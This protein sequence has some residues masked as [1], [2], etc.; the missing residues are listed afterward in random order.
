MSN[1]IQQNSET[2]LKIKY[3]SEY[4]HG[5]ARV[6]PRHRQGKLGHLRTTTTIAVGAPPITSGL[7]AVE[8][9]AA[10]F[11]WLRHYLHS[12]VPTQYILTRALVFL[13]GTL[14]IPW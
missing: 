11:R 4:S 10:A 5:S 14:L 2:Y 1:K 7:I 6:L 13:G 12:S 8:C 3:H 9:L